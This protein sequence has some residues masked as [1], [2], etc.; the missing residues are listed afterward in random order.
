[1]RLSKKQLS[2]LL[3]IVGFSLIV[4][5][6]GGTWGRAYGQT[7]GPTPTPGEVINPISVTKAVNPSTGQPDDLL[8]FSIQIRNND[9]SP[10]TNVVFND[11]ILDFLEIV[12]VSST[13]G[14]ASFSGQEAR[15]EIGTLEPGETVTVT[16]VVRI[17]S[18]AQGGDSGV[19]VASITADSGSAG[20]GTV[21]S[22]PVAISVGQSPPTGLPN[23][24]S[25]SQPNPGLIGS[26]LVLFVLGISA[27]FKARQPVK[28]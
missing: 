15:V 20:T 12:S 18:T 3:C 17:R 27:L 5:G 10:Q 1:M 14:T 11:R 7:A 2:S 22:N 23:T 24:G 21:V 9:S 19:N 6:W 25:L 4:V 26:G 8:T 28:P 16:I 13:K